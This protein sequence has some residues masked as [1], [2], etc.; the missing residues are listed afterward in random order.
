[1]L[2]PFLTLLVILAA[3]FFIYKKTVKKL[4]DVDK[5]AMRD[6]IKDRKEQI[7]NINAGYKSVK[8]VDMKEVRKKKNAVDK[9]LNE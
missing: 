1:M 7:Q 2:I 9:F 4:E 3:A 8:D 5:E 6:G